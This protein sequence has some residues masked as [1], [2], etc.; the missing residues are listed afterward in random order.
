MKKTFCTACG[1]DVPH[2]AE[3]CPHCDASFQNKVSGGVLAKVG[4]FLV[5]FVVGGMEIVLWAILIG[6]IFWVFFSD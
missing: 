3:V 1:K 6:F 4:D 2:D 5:D